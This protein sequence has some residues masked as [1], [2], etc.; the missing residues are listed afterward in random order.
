MV[1]TTPT[2]LGLNFLTMSLAFF[3]VP[4][5]ILHYFWYLFAQASVQ[6]HSQGCQL[7]GVGAGELY[8]FA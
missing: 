1:P 2:L 5:R 7:P 6:P 8:T 4:T 3:M